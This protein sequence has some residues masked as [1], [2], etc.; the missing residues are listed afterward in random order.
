MANWID[1]LDIPMKPI[2]RGRSR[3]I[4]ERLVEPS[5]Q[6]SAPPPRVA[7]TSHAID[8]H[9]SESGSP[10]PLVQQTAPP[11]TH[12]DQGID[13]GTLTVGLEVSFSGEISSCDRLLVE[14]TAHAKIEDCENLTIADTGEFK[15]YASSQNVDVRGRFQGDLVVRRLLIRAT[16]HVSGK[17]TYGEI[18]IERGGQISGKIHALE[19]GGFTLDWNARRRASTGE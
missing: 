12:P 4:P 18:M 8:P 14:G 19:D 2:R 16:G 6:L 11:V 9:N 13:A 17:V 7:E 3:L 1:D 10:A 15:G 5:V